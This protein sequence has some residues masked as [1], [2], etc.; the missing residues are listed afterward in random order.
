MTVRDSIVAGLRAELIGPEDDAAERLDRFDSPRIRYGAG[1]LFPKASPVPFQEDDNQGQAPAPDAAEESSSSD[2]GGADDAGSGLEPTADHDEE[3]NRANDYL[4]SAM[5]ITVRADLSH[6]L[7]I[8][9]R[10]AHYQRVR[11]SP[12]PGT[13]DQPAAGEPM[14]EWQR[15]PIQEV[16]ELSPDQVRSPGTVVLR[17]LLSTAGP[18]QE[19]ALH[20]LVRRAPPGEIPTH[21]FVTVTLLNNAVSSGTYANDEHCF[22]QCSMR[23]E[24]ID[25]TS[26]FLPLP[27]HA[28]SSE[29][30]AESRSAELLFRHRKTYGV[31]HG[32]AADWLEDGG[33]TARQVWTNTLPTYE[34]RPILPREFDELDFRMELLADETSPLPLQV[35]MQLADRYETWI[36]ERVREAS[37][38]SRTP[39]HL[40][41]VAL[42]H[43]EQCRACLYRMRRGIEQ[44]GA[45]PVAR[46][47]FALMNRA[48]LMQQIHYN[49]YATRPRSWVVQGTTRTLS[50]PFVTPTYKGTQNRWRPFQL[51]FILMTIPSIVLS[52]E[53]ALN[54]REF[55]DVI[56]FPTGGGKTEAYLGL[57]AFTILWRRLVQPANA[58]TTVL[59]RYTLRLL[60]TQQFDRASSL[61]CALERLRRDD[62]RGLGQE[63]ISIGLWVGGGVTPNRNNDAV[64]ALNR[65]AAGDGANPF[66]VLRC[67]WCGAGMGALDQEDNRRR[68]VFVAGYRKLSNPARVE[69]ACDDPS[70]DFTSARGGLPLHVV[71]EQVYAR[72]PTLIVGTVDKFAMLPWYPEARSI[73]GIGA[74]K[75]P[76]D[77]IIQDEL[78]LISGPLGSMVGHYETL[79]DL[80]CR[81]DTGVR[82]SG[83]KI[84]AS[85]ATISRAPQQI[86]ALYGRPPESAFLFPPQALRAGDSFFAEEREDRPGRLYVGVFASGLPSQITA[87]VRVIASLLQLPKL[88]GSGDA[89]IDPYWT[90]VAYFNSIRELGHAATLV[91]SDIPERLA[92]LAR[93]FGLSERDGEGRSKLRRWINSELEL[94][95]RVASSDI[96][97]TLQALFRR[98]DQ[99]NNAVDVCLA[100]NMIQVGLDVPRLGLMVVVGQP[101][102]TAE[103]I[104]ATSRVGRSADGPG[105]VVDVLSTGKPRDRSHYEYFRPFHQAIYRHV[106]PT[107]VTPFS[108]RVRERALH[109][110]A[111]ALVRFWDDAC[112][113]SPDPAP[114]SATRQR[115]TDAIM[116]RVQHVDPGEAVLT[117]R[118]LDEFFDVW[119]R[120]RP[121]L[122]GT[123]R[124]RPE[125][126]PLMYPAGSMPSMDWNDLVAHETPSSMRNVDVE[127]QA[128]PLWQ[129]VEQAGG[130]E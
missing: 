49:N 48:M 88:A 93:R 68:G 117:R 89:A 39:P 59:M 28:T 16:V 25:G 96:T 115:V 99:N 126:T 36:E 11:T 56:W 109:A 123:F 80:F 55:V 125:E 51:A 34:I 120:H 92:V 60:T 44:L 111:T 107:S 17:R 75:D 24:S 13:P 94:T 73:F 10:S 18:G 9:V 50:E 6:G 5:G 7:K 61:V 54:E 97:E 42:L 100:T 72:R 103:Y 78:H 23:L 33:S 27:E 45:D 58:G 108:I 43:L 91:R 69:F 104:Q 41:D 63:P 81:R 53:E 40:V 110:I 65:M 67:P 37:D 32:V 70:C 105:L 2:I 87:Q 124:K 119:E 35:C 79:I 74:D 38:S 31:G 130:E 20:I 66:V 71:D 4:P 64:K 82:S 84:V 128:L 118:A 22:F 15:I 8:H 129:Y 121:A 86:A 98:H 76:P 90:L 26:G 114:S 101:K 12:S 127:C 102:T 95:S 52:D 3:V 21:R 46:V 83:A 47:A 106:E 29:D 112:R 19:F 116:D 14:T 113:Y 30:D 85:T 122:Y 1:I 62:T 77:L 57:A